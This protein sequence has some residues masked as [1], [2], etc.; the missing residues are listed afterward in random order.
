MGQAEALASM[1]IEAKR[2]WSDPYPLAL[3]DRPFKPTDQN[4]VFIRH[5]VIFGDGERTALGVGWYRY[6]GIQYLSV[7][8]QTGSG[9]QSLYEYTDRIVSR[10]T[11]L[12][13]I[14]DS[15]KVLFQVASTIK[16]P[17]DANGYSQLQVVCPFYF[18]SRS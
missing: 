16:L 6:Q 9:V 1:E 11:D 5:S 4:T 2:L 13:L 18:D 8:Y 14:D 10:Y 3:T 15:S 17:Q 12:I 7:F